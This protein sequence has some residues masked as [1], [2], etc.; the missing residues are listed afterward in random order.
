MAGLENRPLAK[1]VK[2]LVSYISKTIQDHWLLIHAL[3]APWGTLITAGVLVNFDNPNP[4]IWMFWRYWNDIDAMSVTVSYGAAVYGCTVSATEVIVRM[5]FYAI[6]KILEERERRRRDHERM[7]DEARKEGLEQGL[8]QGI[9]RGLEQ[10]IDLTLNNPGLEQYP[11]LRE[12]IR[13][14]V[15]DAMSGNGR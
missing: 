14:D 13:K 4:D 7:L 5:A 6:A 9:E 15:E 10:G 1:R 12:R 11:E 2:L 8:E 3:V